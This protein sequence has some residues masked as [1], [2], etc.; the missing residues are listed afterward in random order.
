M[1][2]KRDKADILFSNYVR[3]LANWKC[4]KCGTQYKR[5]SQGLHASHFFGRRAEST[6]F[7]LDNVCPH[8]FACHQFLGSNPNEFVEWKK[9]QLGQKRYDELVVKHNT[10]QKKDRK[11][12]ALIWEQALQDLCKEKG[13]DPKFEKLV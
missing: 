4:A 6:R 2:I 7:D 12:Q 13:I 1:K 10:H 9:K 5:K 11:M 8:C 3:E